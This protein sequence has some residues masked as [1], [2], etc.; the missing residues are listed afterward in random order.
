MIINLITTGLSQ[1]GAEESK[2]DGGKITDE[3]T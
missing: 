1:A 2:S 3:P